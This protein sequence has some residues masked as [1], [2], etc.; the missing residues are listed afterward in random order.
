MRKKP[1]KAG[2]KLPSKANPAGEKLYQ[3]SIVVSYLFAE[4]GWLDFKHES[5][6]KRLCHERASIRA[7]ALSSKEVAKDRSLLTFFKE[8]DPS[9]AVRDLA[10]EL[11][12]KFKA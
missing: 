2:K 12:K 4:R 7:E 3:N 10:G 5:V 11:L 8:N 6:M 1:E 9:P